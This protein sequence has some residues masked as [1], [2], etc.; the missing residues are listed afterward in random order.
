MTNKFSII[1]PTMWKY[2][3][4]IRFLEDL[5]DHDYVDEIILINNDQAALP[6]NCGVLTHSKIK[7]YNFLENIGVNPAW[8]LGVNIA[9]NKQICL[10]NDDMVF[11]LTLLK[12]VSKVLS[13]DTGVIG[14]CNENP[15]TTG[16]IDIHPWV[17]QNTLGFGC[18]MFVHKDW[19]IDIP[20]QLKIYYGDNWIFDTCLIRNKPIYVITDLL[21]KTEWATTSRYTPSHVIHDEGALYNIFIDEFRKNQLK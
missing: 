11:D 13:A 3:P 16:C 9:S 5:V 17:G 4:H 19:W 8:N 20:S 7:I 12:K 6:K 18:L 21:Y 2:P 14:I 15:P 1:T 10:L